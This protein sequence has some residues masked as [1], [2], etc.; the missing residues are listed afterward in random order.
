VLRNSTHAISA[1]APPPTPL[2]RATICG[3][4]VILTLV[5]RAWP[6]GSV[7]M[8]A[9][10]VAAD[11]IGGTTGIDQPPNAPSGRMRW[12]VIIRYGIH[13]AVTRPSRA[14][15]VHSVQSTAS[16][17][18]SNLNGYDTRLPDPPPDAS[19]APFPTS[20]TTTVLG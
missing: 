4:A 11:T 9:A 2:N 13:T 15:P 16:A 5:S 12:L 17:A 14:P 8:S 1:T 20:L 7:G 19:S 6:A 18:G 3:I 10:P